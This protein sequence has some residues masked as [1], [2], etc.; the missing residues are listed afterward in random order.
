MLL[1]SRIAASLT[2]VTIALGSTAPAEALGRNE[3][4]FLKGIAAALIVGAI[5]NEGRK[6]HAAPAPQPLYR[7]PVYRQPTYRE[8]QRQQPTY[9]PQRKPGRIIGS[10]G[11]NASQYG[12][13][14]NNTTAARVFN[15]YSQMERF[16][17]QRQ[18][19]AFG[20]Y[21]G[22]IDGSFGPRTYQAIYQFALAGGKQEALSN[23]SGAYQVYD[24]LL[25]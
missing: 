6:S 24:A 25:G 18:L 15:S 11:G 8:P 12:S 20:Y 21:S 23:T 7:E 10:S 2:A 4:N 17:I 3:R 16:R 13:G 9:Q 14:V 22:S 5:V 19:A 1:R